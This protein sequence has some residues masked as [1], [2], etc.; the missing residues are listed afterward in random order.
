MMRTAAFVAT[1]LPMSAWLWRDLSR[2]VAT[3]PATALV[4]M[5]LATLSG[6]LSWTLLN[7][8]PEALLPW[9]LAMLLLTA[10][11]LM[12]CWRRLGRLPQALPAGRLA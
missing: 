9:A 12:W 7:A 5:L 11:L 2:Q 3:T 6:G 8:R 1:A 4:I 10:G